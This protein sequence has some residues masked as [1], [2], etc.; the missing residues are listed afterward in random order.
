MHVSNITITF[1]SRPGLSALIT[2]GNQAHFSKKLVLPSTAGAVT[3][4]R[5]ILL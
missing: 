2:A 1:V 5:S 3:G 4:R